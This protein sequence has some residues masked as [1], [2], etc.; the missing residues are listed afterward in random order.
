MRRAALA[1][2]LLLGELLGPV[3]WLA[4]TCVV[5]ASVGVTRSAARP[6]TPPVVN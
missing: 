3:E 1:G 4:I 6:A 5:V 2:L